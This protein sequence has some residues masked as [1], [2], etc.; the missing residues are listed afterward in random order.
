[1][2]GQLGWAPPCL[3]GAAARHTQLHS[4]L[5]FDVHHKA[6]TC[7]SFTRGMRVYRRR[8]YAC[9]LY[10]VP[11]RTI[12]VTDYGP[13]L[14]RKLSKRERKIQDGPP[15]RQRQCHTAIPCHLARVVRSGMKVQQC[16]CEAKGVFRSAKIW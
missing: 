10:I 12:Q 1:V 15:W 7:M 9:S 4:G 6:P 2:V 14:Q 3:P 5:K 13:D 11:S 16:T 8:T